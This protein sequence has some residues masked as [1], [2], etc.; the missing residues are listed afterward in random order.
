MFQVVSDPWRIPGLVPLFESAAPGLTWLVGLF[1]TWGRAG[2]PYAHPW[3]F[4]FIPR[5]VVVCGEPGQ[6]GW[7]VVVA[8][9]EQQGVE[10]CK[11]VPGLHAARQLSGELGLVQAVLKAL[12]ELE[13]RLLRKQEFSCLRRLRQGPTPPLPPGFRAARV[14]DVPRLMSFDLV[15][16]GQDPIHAEGVLR[17]RILRKQ[18]FVV[19]EGEEV[20]SMAELLP[21]GRYLDIQRVATL[22]AFRQRGYGRQLLEGLVSTAA[23]AGKD[24][25]LCVDPDNEVALHL[26]RGLGFESWGRRG[27]FYF[28]A[29]PA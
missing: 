15:P 26:Y 4:S 28:G 9:E 17:T 18:V 16:P 11:Q 25:S 1:E 13:G 24:T 8:V 6:T 27:D 19:G 23:Q 3:I 20:V 22:P 21:A 29:A 12:P 10:L 2:R 7:W 14:R 5:R